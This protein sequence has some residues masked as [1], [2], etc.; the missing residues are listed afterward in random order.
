MQWQE[1]SAWQGLNFGV[2]DRSLSLSLW[3]LNMPVALQQ[4][5]LTESRIVN[6]L[7]TPRIWSRWRH[8]NMLL[9]AK[10]VMP[11]PHFGCC[12]LLIARFCYLLFANRHGHGHGRH[13]M[14]WTASLCKEKAHMNDNYHQE[15][16]DDRGVW[17]RSISIIDKFELY[18]RCQIK[19]IRIFLFLIASSRNKTYRKLYLMWS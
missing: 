4:S 7:D 3:I 19:Y 11:L 10:P 13:A 9:S 14:A 16:L 17:G 12:L 5:V 15:W 18:F 8:W 6:I 2:I 1:S